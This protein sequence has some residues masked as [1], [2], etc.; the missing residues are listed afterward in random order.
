M[1]GAV[2]EHAHDGVHIIAQG[3]EHGYESRTRHD[4]GKQH[5]GKRPDLCSIWTPPVA[6]AK[7]CLSST[8]T[9]CA[10]VYW[11]LCLQ[12]ARLCSCTGLD[13][14]LTC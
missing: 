10:V 8:P 9:P 2:A 5:R 11:A 7:P 13:E 4:C 12:V 6:A 1:L 3:F 14:R